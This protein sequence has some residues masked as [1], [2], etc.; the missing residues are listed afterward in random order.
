M[1]YIQVPN[2]LMH[3]NSDGKNEPVNSVDFHPSLPLLASGGAGDKRL[4]LWQVRAPSRPYVHRAH[5]LRRFPHS[6]SSK[7]RL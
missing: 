1:P 2:I 7:Q 3:A 5:A 4:L 6:P